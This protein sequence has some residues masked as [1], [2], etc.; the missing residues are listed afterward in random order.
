[1]HLSAVGAAVRVDGHS[2]TRLGAPSG[3]GDLA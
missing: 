1:M 3:I 2:F